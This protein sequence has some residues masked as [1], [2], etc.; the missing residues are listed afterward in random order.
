MQNGELING[1]QKL[2]KASEP[3][4]FP[5]LIH[6]SARLFSALAPFSPF[7]PDKEPGARIWNVPVIAGSAWEQFYL[8]IDVL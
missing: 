4:H 5:S 3:G 7:F 8:P 6:I 2:G 1:A